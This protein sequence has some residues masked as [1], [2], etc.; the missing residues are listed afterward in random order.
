MSR[1]I[2]ICIDGTG[3]HPDD[4]D[5][6]DCETTN[7]YRLFQAFSEDDQQLIKYIPGVGTSGLMLIDAKGE[8]TG[9]GASE[10]RE[11]AHHFLVTIY[12]PS[13]EIYMFGFS[14]GA[15]IVRDLANYIYDYG[16]GNFRNVAIKMLGLWDTVAAFGIP[17]DVL[18]LPT[19]STNLGKKLDVPP[20]VQQTY[21]LLS[22]DE[23]RTPFIP[24]L[25]EAADTVEEV[26]FAGVH[27]DVGG[28]FKERRL[29]NIS[30]WFMIERA[31]SHGLRFKQPALREIPRNVTGE[32]I[33]HVYQGKLPQQPREILVRK[34]NKPSTLQ[35]KIHKTV[36]E[37]IKRQDY[38]PINVTKLNDNFVVVE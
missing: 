35:P 25:V 28:G 4:D 30:L 34:D 7:V 14:R 1:N 10:K 31:Q 18:G 2:V 5:E 26:W 8:M 17:I 23:Q 22:I 20:N 19:Q 36:I 9:F 6:P 29:A 12:K 13:D 27:A 15:A 37:R 16:L 32:G 33:I 11:E 38:N 3:N 24:T 21:H